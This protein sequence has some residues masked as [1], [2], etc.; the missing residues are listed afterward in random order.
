MGEDMILTLGLA[1]VVLPLFFLILF[2]ELRRLSPGERA[3]MKACRA[4]LPI[5]LRAVHFLLLL[6]VWLISA[7][8][9]AAGLVILRFALHGQDGFGE[10]FGTFLLAGAYA[11]LGSALL[12]AC[13]SDKVIAP[14]THAA[15]IAASGIQRETIVRGNRLVMR[16][17]GAMIVPLLA[18]L[19][20]AGFA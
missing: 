13:V 6:I 4:R 5:W 7:A 12:F 3:Q 11:G 8:V 18:G 16:L 2:H 19:A 15:A 10:I 9:V 17:A 20:I 14:K 1:A